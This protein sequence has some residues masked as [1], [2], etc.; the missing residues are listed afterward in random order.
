MTQLS[1]GSSIG[2][3]RSDNGGE[4]LSTEFVNYL[5]SKGIQHELTVPNAPEQ[6]GVSERINRTLME[7]A[8]SMLSHAGLQNNFWAEAVATAAYVRNR[9]PASTLS[10]GVTPYQ[11]W[12]GH[13]P[14]LEHL[15][16]FG[17]TAYAHVPDGQRQ[18]LDKK[19]KKF[20]FVGYSIQSKG[21]RL[22]DEDTKRILVRRD[23]VFNES[24]FGEKLLL[25]DEGS[26]ESLEIS[27]EQS[28][29][30]ETVPNHGQEHASQDQINQEQFE[31][32]TIRRS[33]RHRCPPVRYGCD[34]YVDLA[35]ES[36]VHHVAY[37]SQVSEPTSLKEAL[38]SKN[39]R[40]WKQAADIEYNALVENK[41]WDLVEPPVGCKPIGCRWLFKVKH[42]S[43]G[44]IEKYKGSQ[45]LLAD[46]WD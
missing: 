20:R 11:K 33:E 40:E 26:V 5:K 27:C 1:T 29:N 28:K 36:E 45:G 42:R 16:V 35:A 6:N 38:Q 41:T 8:R 4:Y 46:I 7:S 22:L 24:N 18:K 34:E 23:V 37:L 12:Y 2:A 15:R 3:L 25:N 44:E 31:E 30:A 43:T 13:K 19:A 10:E 9:S 39:A 17:C 32:R 21:Y 14:N